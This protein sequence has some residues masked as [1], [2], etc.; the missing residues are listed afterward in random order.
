MELRFSDPMDTSTT[1]VAGSYTILPEVVGI[2]VDSALVDPDNPEVVRLWTGPAPF[3]AFGYVYTVVVD[4]AIKNW[5]GTPVRERRGDRLSF[6]LAQEDLDHL[7]VFPN[8]YREG[9]GAKHI[10]FANLTPQ[11]TIRVFTLAG[12]LVRTL[13]GTNTCGVLQWDLTNK[14]GRKVASGIYL[15]YVEGNGDIR[16]G[17][18]AIIR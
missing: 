8:P 12:K 13:K 5:A 9:S 2:G 3:G 6:Q 7:L 10:T 1:K 18:L 17:K 4:S 14:Y 11:A 15:Y 16:R